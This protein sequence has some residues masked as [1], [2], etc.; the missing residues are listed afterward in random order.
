MIQVEEEALQIS[1]GSS[2]HR[3]VAS[4]EKLLLRVFWCVDLQSWS[5]YRGLITSNMSS[6]ILICVRHR[7]G[8]MYCKEEIALFF[9]VGVDSTIK[10]EI[11]Y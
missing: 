10:T 5:G 1:R 9:L 7:Y 4:P 8:T 6:V 11:M 2:F 3:L